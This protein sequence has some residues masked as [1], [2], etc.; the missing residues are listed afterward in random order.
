MKNPIA[1]YLRVVR[2]IKQAKR[3]G[4]TEEVLKA[5]KENA[6]LQKLTLQPKRYETINGAGEIGWGLATLC[7]AISSYAS[8][9]LPP[10]AWRIWSGWFFLASA[11]VAMP[12]CLWASRKF[13]TWP[14]VGYVTFRRD[15][16]WWLG[17]IVAVIL[18]GVLSA[19]LP[20]LLMREM[21]H[22]EPGVVH[23]AGQSVVRLHMEPGAPTTAGNILKFTF[24]PLSAILYLM[25]NAVSIKEHRWKWLL[26]LLIATVPVG[27]TF[28]VPGPYIEVC[29]PM[30]LALGP[31][32]LLSGIIT[33]ASFIRHH[34]PPTSE[35]E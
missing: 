17:I 33:L 32:W 30:M 34:Q 5:V 19:I 8:R 3:E 16:S 14:R 23:A 31:L 12:L 26:F 21:P 10:S 27:I 9:I 22:P 11:C 29:R 15:K 25:F 7:F 20:F 35:T 18:S 1:E 4:R 2:I 13:V 6:E 28:L 24:G